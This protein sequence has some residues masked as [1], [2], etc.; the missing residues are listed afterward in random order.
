MACSHRY[1]IGCDMVVRD[2]ELKLSA[3][4]YTRLLTQGS[5]MRLLT[6]RWLHKVV[7]TRLLTRG[8]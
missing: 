3:G 5:Y 2:R 6:Q 8:C 1:R 4:C 7:N